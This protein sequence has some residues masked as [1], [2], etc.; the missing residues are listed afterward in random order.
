MEEASPEPINWSALPFGATAVGGRGLPF[1]Q[2]ITGSNLWNW[3]ALKPRQARETETPQPPLRWLCVS[4]H[5]SV[6]PR[7]YLWSLLP[8]SVTQQKQ[9]ASPAK[10]MSRLQNSKLIKKNE[11]QKTPNCESAFFPL[12]NDDSVHTF[13]MCYNKLTSCIWWCE[14]HKNTPLHSKIRKRISE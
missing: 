5:S 6:P 4:S 9:N 1:R 8:R 12:R 10:N 2:F 11:S 3:V 7:S 13:G 14:I